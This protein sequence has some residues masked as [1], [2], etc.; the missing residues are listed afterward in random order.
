M[1]YIKLALAETL[2]LKKNDKFVL[3]KPK[4]GIIII[5][6]SGCPKNQNICWNKTASPPPE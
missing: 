5:Y 4:I 1:E 3:I 6:T 2:F